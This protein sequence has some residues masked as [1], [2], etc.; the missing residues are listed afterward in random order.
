MLSNPHAQNKDDAKFWY[1]PCFVLECI[2]Q[3]EVVNRDL[4]KSLSKAERKRMQEARWGAYFLLGQT[5]L[6]H[7]EYWMQLPVNDPP[8]LISYS[9]PKIGNRTRRH[10]QDVELVEFNYHSN[11]DLASHIYETKLKNKKKF[12]T[13]ILVVMQRRYE[14]NSI[15]VSQNLTSIYHENTPH[16]WVISS[17]NYG[18]LFTIT[19]GR[20]YPHHSKFL[21]FVPM[22][23]CMKSLN[24]QSSH[25]RFKLG[26]AS[27]K[28]T[29]DKALANIDYTEPFRV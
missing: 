23:T 2:R 8:D 12:A 22:A 28:I 16:I 18:K 27:K 19:L 20:I 13:N 7:L 11:E 3:I 5:C 15:A 9:L 21:N 6:N 1:S 29:S 4:L 14:E 24:N 10:L 25:V 17:R 26:A